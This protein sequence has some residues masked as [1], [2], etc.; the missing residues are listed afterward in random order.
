MTANDL[1]GGWL[2]PT[3][4]LL[5]VAALVGFALREALAAPADRLPGT[6]AGI[7]YAWEIST[8]AALGGGELPYWN[9]YQFSGMP[10]LADPQMMVLYPPA[11]LLRWIPAERFLAWLAALH[12]LIGAAGTVFL[13]RALGLTIA[14]EG[15]VDWLLLGHG[16][17]MVREDVRADAA[18]LWLRRRA[19]GTPVEYVALDVG[20]LVV[21]GREIVAA[22]ERRPWS[23]GRLDADGPDGT[24]DHGRRGVS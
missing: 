2:R 11:V 20:E 9:P 24:T 12:L 22:G 15:L 6:D 3:A 5:V 14:H 21:A 1:R 19:D 10:H 13:G 16:D 23:A 4:V 7:H 18:W 17:V 8:R